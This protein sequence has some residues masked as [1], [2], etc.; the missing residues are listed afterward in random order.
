VAEREKQPPRKRKRCSKCRANL[1]ASA[2]H[3][4]QRTAS[5]LQSSCKVCATPL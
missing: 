4:N 2:F 3:K 1:L 5:G